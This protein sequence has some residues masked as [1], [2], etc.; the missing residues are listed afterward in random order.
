MIILTHI[1]QYLPDYLDSFL[2]QLKKFNPNYDIVFLVNNVNCENELFKT[3]NIKTYP[4]E[5]L[6]SDRVNHFINIFGYGN[7]N[8]VHQNIIYGGADYWCVTATRLFFIYEYCIKNNITKFFHFE[9]D[10]MI[11]EDLNKIYELISKNNLYPNQISITR[12]TNN[13]IMTGFMYV[14]NL[15]VLN[16]LLS[17]ICYYLESKMDLLQFGID[18]LNEMSLLHVYQQLN[19]DKMVNL[20]IFPNHTITEDFKLFQSVFDP[21]TY[22]QYLD[23]HPGE[24]GVSILPES[25]IGE[26]FKKNS[27]IK[28][29]FDNV[30][31]NKIPFINYNGV[32]TKI[33]SLHIHS[34]RLNLFLS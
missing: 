21:A 19:P 9:N 31:G 10:I 22:G 8:T 29:I 30:D 5:N 14:D 23:G 6:I 7:T 26:E 15:E 13:K 32:L 34:K 4:I 27:D 2:T 11:Y 17:E 1:G 18:H 3:H 25:I 28:I 33:N 12:G 24:P 16:H 20:P